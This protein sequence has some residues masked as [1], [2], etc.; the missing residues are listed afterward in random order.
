MPEETKGST[1]VE[2]AEELLLHIKDIS[3]FVYVIMDYFDTLKEYN[4]K[5]ARVAAFSNYYIIS[6][7]CWHNLDALKDLAELI[8][9]KALERWRRG[10]DKDD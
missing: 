4:T 3:A 2:L 7:M 6:E 5:K 10:D 1:D 9:K 8:E